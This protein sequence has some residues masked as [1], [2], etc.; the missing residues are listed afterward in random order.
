MEIDVAETVNLNSI[1]IEGRLSFKDDASLPQIKLRANQIWN[2]REFK[3]G[4]PDKPFSQKA[5]I[6]LTGKADAPTLTLT[7]TIKG[8]NKIIASSK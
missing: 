5:L 4:A 7:G 8:G 1:K 2:N 6:E 3:I